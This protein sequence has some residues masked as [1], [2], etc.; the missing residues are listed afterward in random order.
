MLPVSQPGN[1][2]LAQAL[3]AYAEELREIRAN[4]PLPSSL[5]YHPYPMYDQIGMF[6]LHLKPQ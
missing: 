4:K 3:P 6:I 5:Q 1:K 2:L